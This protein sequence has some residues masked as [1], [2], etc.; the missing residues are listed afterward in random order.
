MSIIQ[1]SA[2]E[3]VEEAKR[4]RWRLPAYGVTALLVIA[5]G[6]AVLPG[7]WSIPPLIESD[8]CYLLTASDRFHEGNGLTATPPVAPL[9]PWSW[10]TD[11]AFLTKWP[12]GYPIMIAAIRSLSGCSTIIACQAISTLACAAALVGWFLLARGCVPRGVAGIL[13]ALLAAGSSVTTA[14]LINPSTD[15]IVVAVLPFVLLLVPAG[16]GMKRPGPPRIGGGPY[17]LPLIVAGL[18][19]GSLFWIR[20]SSIFVPVAIG[21]FLLLIAFARRRTAYFRAF[22]AFSFSAAVPIVILMIVNRTFGIDG[23]TQAQLNLGTTIGFDFS[24]ELPLQAW[25]HWTDF[26]FYDHYGA[27]HWVFAIWPAILAVLAATFPSWRA[28]VRA[29]FGRPQ[30]RLFGAVAAGL[31]GL[32]VVSSTLFANKYNYVELERYYLAIRPLYFLLFIAPLMFLPFRAIKTALALCCVVACCWIVRQEWP[33]PYYRW[34]AADREVTPYG[35]WAKCFSPG[36]TDLYAYL[37]DQADDRLVVVSNFHEWIALET[38]IPALPIPP[39]RAALDQWVTEICQRRHID[40]ANVV[41]V[42]DRQNKWRDYWIRPPASVM[43]DFNLASDLAFMTH[44]STFVLPYAPSPIGV[45]GRVVS[46][47]E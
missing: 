5:A 27:S 31:L 20:Y 22:Q 12:C 7:R 44:P 29:Y 3:G 38:G 1:G 10:K 14:L 34:M 35:Q 39:D 28:A 40:R 32:L 18:I 23:S 47:T 36:S 42:L 11:W 16:V 8:Y 13:L 17:W 26:G 37:R 24:V 46:G 4:P 2:R 21:V 43:V 33:R 45:A 9:Q 19:S 15:L 30:A 41:F 6:L 25:W